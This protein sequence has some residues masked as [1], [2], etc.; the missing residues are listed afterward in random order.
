[1][2]KSIARQVF[3]ASGALSAARWLKRRRLRILM[4]HRFHDRES[5][6]RQCA[7]IRAHYR[8]VSLTQAADWLLN[9]GGWPDNAL[10]V[11]VDD[12]YRDFHQIA[13]PVFRDYG[14]PATVYASRTRS[15]RATSTTVADT[16]GHCREGSGP[17]TRTTSRPSLP[18]TNAIAGQSMTRSPLSDQCAFGR[19]CCRSM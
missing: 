6:A 9:R 2:I 8:P 10:V 5:I 1:M 17:E 7:H 13:Y 12:G 16:V 3:H 11:T 14:I 15:R 18:E 4:Y 19:V